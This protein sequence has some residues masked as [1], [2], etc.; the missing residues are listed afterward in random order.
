MPLNV[1]WPRPQ[2]VSI[3]GD[4]PKISDIINTVNH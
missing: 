4:N 3:T 2:P 1:Y